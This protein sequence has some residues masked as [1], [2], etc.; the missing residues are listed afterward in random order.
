MA[1][2]E[3]MEP[4]KQDLL[5]PSI[6][7]KLDMELKF[8]VKELLEAEAAPDRKKLTTAKRAVEDQV[9]RLRA[10]HTKLSARLTALGEKAAK[11]VAVSP[12]AVALAKALTA[13]TGT[14]HTAETGDGTI[15]VGNR[16][17]TVESQVWS[18]KKAN[19]S[20]YSNPNYRRRETVEFTADMDKLVAEL[21]E[22]SNQIADAQHL[23]DQLQTELA[24]WPSVIQDAK[25]EL[26]RRHA[27]GDIRTTDDVIGAL[28]DALADHRRQLPKLVGYTED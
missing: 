26:I 9:S 3:I 28:Q 5:M 7:L 24:R 25:D 2:T 27:R 19:R 1:D 15:D 13:F 14:A 12:L 21:E 23:G 18:D 8:D 10:Q 16:T 17:I 22:L 6:G 11:K 20:S 4:T